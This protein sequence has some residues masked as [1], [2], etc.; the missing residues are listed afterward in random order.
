[1]ANRTEWAGKAVRGIVSAKERANARQE[2]LDHIEDHMA[3]LLAA[4]FTL[5][6]AEKQAVFAMGDP[7]T[8]A[9]LLRKTHQPVLT[10]LL[11]L[12]RWLTLA[13]LALL[14]LHGLPAAVHRYQGL[15]A[16]LPP[17]SY[18]ENTEF[19]LGSAAAVREIS[20]P[21]ETIP[22][23]DYVFSL[24]RVIVRQ[25]AQPHPTTGEKAS[26]T[27]LLKARADRFWRKRPPI[28]EQFRL[29]DDQGHTY[30]IDQSAEGMV[31][32]TAGQQG[33]DFYWV[34][35]APLA[36]DTRWVQLAFSNGQTAFAF[37]CTVEEGSA[38]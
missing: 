26:V 23:T 37:R 25:L 35:N 28:G 3:D 2:L 1:M 36:P 19:F 22:L 29:T 12:L 9:K 27:L 21:K 14:L 13:A 30:T 16:N 6:E 24:E 7:E 33:R 38:P 5:E 10:R 4:G 32:G 18:V 17:D 34:F 20:P 31:W 8:T 11:Q 15:W